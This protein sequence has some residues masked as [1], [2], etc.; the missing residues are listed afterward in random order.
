VDCP[1]VTGRLAEL[2]RPVERVDDPDS[3]AREPHQVVGRLLT[4][5]GVIGPVQGQEVRERTLTRLVPGIL[6]FG[7]REVAAGCADL[8]QAAPGALRGRHCHLTVREGG[9]AIVCCRFVSHGHEV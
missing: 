4:Q 7:G 1:V 9:L 8:E 2:T 6:E 5:D 3:I